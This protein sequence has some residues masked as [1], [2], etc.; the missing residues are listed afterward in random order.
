MSRPARATLD[1]PLA[2]ANLHSE[3]PAAV[4][5]ATLSAPPL[6]AGDA[7]VYAAI[8]GAAVLLW[9]LAAEHSSLLP[10]WAPW[11]FSFVEFLAGWLAVFWYLRGLTRTPAAARPSRA[12]RA[13]CASGT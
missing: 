10:V 5:P 2:Q 11:D 9:W 7:V 13:A 8:F 12:R 1:G 4:G 3:P 6:R